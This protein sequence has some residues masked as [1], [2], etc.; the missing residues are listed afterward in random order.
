MLAIHYDSSFDGFLS[1][2]F[3][4]YR[5]H[6]D[7]GDIVP[8]RPYAA[9]SAAATDLFLQPFRI[10]T[11]V[12]SARRLR[13]AIL[14]A[15]G[16]DIMNLLDCAFRSEE[17]GVEMK[18]FAYL[19]KLFAGDNR[20]Y[21]R[22]PTSEEM[23]PLFTIARSVRREQGFMLGAV[24]FAKAPDGMYISAI[25]P[26]YNVVDMLAPH[27][28]SRF[29]NGRWAIVDMVR[30]FGVCYEGGRTQLVS[31]ADPEA[32]AGIE[33]S[34]EFARM[35][36]SYYDSMAIKERLNPELLKRCLPVRYWKHLPERQ[37]DA[38]SLTIGGRNSE[39]RGADGL[40]GAD[41][42]SAVAR[43]RSLALAHAGV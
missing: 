30:R 15:A 7:V 36:K 37:V 5:Q 24:R 29:P 4:I 23:L 43:G 19:R 2:V 26:K 3:E 34:D 28:R 1:V 32:I 22:N 18:I 8:V 21:A 35:W 40:G 17:P 16:E 39:K 41:L 14:N 11:D 27:F 25:E 38:S 42:P 12:E 10:E 33:R 6:L 13:R 31:V 20:G 9:G